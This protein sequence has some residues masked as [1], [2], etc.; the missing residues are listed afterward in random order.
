M[1]DLVKWLTNILDEDE[2]GAKAAARTV[3]SAEWTTGQYSDYVYTVTS[4][5]AQEVAAD[6]YG[7]MNEARRY[8]IARHDPASVLADITAKRAILKIYR[9]FLDGPMPTSAWESGQLKAIAKAV[10]HIASA[11]ADRP[12]HPV[13]RS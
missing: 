6:G 8:F 2:A 13:E 1:S 3:G 9:D 4:G 5:N 12:G 7:H 11:Y 10:H